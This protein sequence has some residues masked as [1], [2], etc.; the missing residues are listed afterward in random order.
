MQTRKTHKSYYL[1]D[2]HSLMDE[3]AT[4]GAP[5]F[6]EELIVKIFKDLGSKYKITTAIR[7]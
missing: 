1:R 7:A 4:I 3:L 2:V 6:N 5:M